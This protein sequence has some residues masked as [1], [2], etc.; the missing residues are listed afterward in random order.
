M[1]YKE[2]CKNNTESKDN[3][4][5]KLKEQEETKK[6]EEPKP[7]PIAR[8]NRPKPKRRAAD[9]KFTFDFGHQKIKAVENG[10]AALKPKTYGGTIRFGR[11]LHF[12]KKNNDN[13]KEYTITFD[14][15]SVGNNSS[16][17]FGFATNS[18]SGWMGSNFGQN[19]SCIV[20]GMR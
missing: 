4:D 13:L 11:Y 8:R 15:R 6:K 7:K 20:K 3:D 2:E 12:T 14:T 19:N 1:Q 16:I 18:F 10:M 17:A 5:S 9:I